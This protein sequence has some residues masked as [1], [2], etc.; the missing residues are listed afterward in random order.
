MSDALIRARFPRV[1]ALFVVAFGACSDDPAPIQTPA[2][3]QVEVVAPAAGTKLADRSATLTFRV[4]DAAAT[5]YTVALNGAAPIRTDAA[6]AAGATVDVPL[7]LDYGT[8]VAVVSVFDAVG[9]SDQVTWTLLVEDAPPAVRASFTVEGPA[10]GTTFTAPSAELAFAVTGPATRWVVTHDD[11]EVASGDAPTGRVT[12]PLTLSTGV[13]TFELALFDAVGESQRETLVYLYQPTTA[14]RPGVVITAPTN[15]AILQVATV[16]V[17]FRVTTAAATG[18]RIVAGDYTHEVA[19]ALAVDTEHT[20][21]LALVDGSNTLTV[22]VLDASGEAATASVAVVVDRPAAPVIAFTSPAPDTVVFDD[23]IAIEGTVDSVAPLASV[24]Y[25]LDDGTGEALELQG[26]AFFLSLPLEVGT[27]TL[28]ITA[29]DDLGVTT[30][31]E[32]AFARE[33]DAVA[34]TL[35]LAFPRDTQAVKTRSVLIRGEVIDNHQLDLVG[36]VQGDTTIPATVSGARFEAWLALEP[37]L[38]AYTLEAV[39]V[40]GNLTRLDS[41]VY[42]GQRLG[43]G[44]ANGGAIKGGKLYTWGRNNLGQTGQGFVSHESRTTWCDRA[45][46]SAVDS[47][48]CKAQTVANV[49]ALCNTV[50]TAGTPAATTCRDAAIA[51]RDALCDTATGAPANCKTATTVNLT[52]LCDTHHGA[53][54]SAASA[55][56]LDIVCAP[57]FPGA[58]NA[59]AS[60]LSSIP[61]TYP[62][63]PPPYAPVA[64]TDVVTADGLDTTAADLGLAFVS[65]AFNQNAASALDTD[66]RIW[67]WG[68]GASGML[69]L[70][71][72]D[73][74]DIPHQ[75]AEFGAAGTRVVALSR[76]FDHLLALRSDG[77]VWG[78]GLNN[79][80]QIGD[81]TS[82]TTNNRL[83]PTQ[84]QGLPA[85]IIQVTASSQSS[86]AL[87][88]SGEVWAWGRN[89]YGNL[90]QG[91]SAGANDAFPAP[92]KVLDL[93][94]VLVL[95]NGR[96][97]VL[98]ARKDGT[99]YSWGLNAS[100]QV[101]PF[102]GN[103]LR[104]VQVPG[105]TDAVAVYGNGNQGFYEDATGRLLGWGQNGTTANLGIPEAANQPLPTIPVF[106]LSAITDCT[107]GPTHGFAMR[108]NTVFA[109]GWSFHGSLGGGNSTIHAWGYRTPILVTLP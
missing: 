51:A 46:T 12:T 78:C 87:T 108:G 55:C 75:V 63:P 9:Q 82:G 98:A 42:F 1:L 74:R 22:T 11:T 26:R 16:D 91:T 34:P 43:A 73:N 65:L 86:Y 30:E 68:D 17:R 99:V 106:G 90:G 62:A 67:S 24:T 20:E 69:C 25:T 49:Q 19:A 3:P 101:G 38:N 7:A 57:T 94:D 21:T 35:T 59:C 31:A 77:T 80:G 28:T 96:D 36:I 102:E 107:I 85:D 60:L 8:N 33:V 66:G 45:L 61:T 64:I 32:L 100:G 53:G 52:N 29:T 44:G 84:V 48:T 89:Q 83:V 79:V 71:D 58:M 2:R 104:P 92:V 27:H 6:V 56:K 41:T 4:T 18:Y 23:A 13:N 37:G 50:H 97:H 103:Q 47:E 88:A 10:T 5:A 39:D 76:G 14:P 109:W 70:G 93:E 54:S 15:G 81:G 95:A 72:I 105:I 40:T